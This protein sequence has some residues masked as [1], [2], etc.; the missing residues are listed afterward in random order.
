VNRGHGHGRGP[1]TVRPSYYMYHDSDVDYHTK[2]HPLFHETKK[3]PDDSAKVSQ[4]S[5]PREVNHTGTSINNTHH[6]TPFFHK[7]TK[8][9]KPHLRHIISP[10]ITT[11]QITCSPAISTN[12]IPPPALEITYPSAILQITYPKQNSNPQV[13][14]ENNP[15]PPPPPQLQEPQQ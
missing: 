6:P 9:V 2:D 10:T 13:K 11:Q 14:I 7:L 8:P 15:P 5:T 4:Q 1:Y 3:K 12:N